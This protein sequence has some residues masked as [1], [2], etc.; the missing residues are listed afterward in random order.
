MTWDE[1]QE[2]ALYR[3]TMDGLKKAYELGKLD[4]ASWAAANPDLA[5]GAV[6][7][8]GGGGRPG[9][10]GGSGASGASGGGGGDGS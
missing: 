10:S 2:L 8:Q 6:G 3:P 7:R 5:A 4:G 9:S 1:W